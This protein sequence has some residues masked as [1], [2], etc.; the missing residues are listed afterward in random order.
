[1]RFL[2]LSLLAASLTA[3]GVASG[4]NVLLWD[5]SSPLGAQNSPE[6]RTNWKAVPSDL[7]TLEKDPPKASSDPG[8]YGREYVFRGD[9]VVE[10]HSMTAVFSSAQGRIVLYA[11]SIPAL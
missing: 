4:A 3:E 5:T 7:L 2:F 6:S 10:N 8:Y 9:A 11:T 1:M